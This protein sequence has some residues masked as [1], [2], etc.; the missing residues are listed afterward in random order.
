VDVTKDRPELSLPLVERKRVI[1]HYMTMMTYSRERAPTD[2]LF[3]PAMYSPLGPAGHLGGMSQHIPLIAHYHG[4]TASLEES[5]AHE[6]RAAIEIGI[7]GFQFYFPARRDRE[8]MELECRIITTFLKVAANDFP[9]FKLTICPSHPNDHTES[10]NIESWA[11]SLNRILDETRTLDSWLKTPDGR[12]VIYLWCP[13][14][15]A[16]SVTPHSIIADHPERM[17][18]VA[19]AYEKLAEACGIQAAYIYHLRDEWTGNA[20]LLEAALDY[21]PA[22]WG[23][24]PTSDD[25]DDWPRIHARCK[26]RGR[27]YT[28]SIFNDFYTSKFYCKKEDFRMIFRLDECRERTVADYW[29][30]YLPC[31]LSR[32]FRRQLQRAIDW[33][34]P[35]LN[36]VTWNDYPEGHHM[37]PEINRNFGFALLLKH[38]KKQWLARPEKNHKEWAAVFFNKYRRA[39]RPDP[40]DFE[41]RPV[42][43]EQAD[44]DFIEVITLLNEPSRL[45]INKTDC[46]LVA[47][48]LQE[49]RIPSEPGQVCVCLKRGGDPF[50]EFE[51]PEG[52]TENPYRTDLTTY[53]FS[54]EFDTFFSRLFPGQDPVYS[55]EYAD[56]KRGL[57]LHVHDYAAPSLI[58]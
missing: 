50:I 38:Y 26:E 58:Q 35:L 21:F 4:Q 24:I 40:F 2:D 42:R 28:Q 13:D 22:I 39:V 5:V 51:T 44:E 57:D 8:G 36:V 49:T 3:N 55:T 20:E 19:L 11:W 34:A 15:L 37:A 56:E 14:G 10:E 29:K 25:D 33:D 23:F 41:V 45:L 48:G 17:R 47:A 31:G 30:R 9:D 18:D 53:S 12:F 46:G 6:I 16:D 52:I 32:A 43:D 1:A 27:V 7:D 54:S